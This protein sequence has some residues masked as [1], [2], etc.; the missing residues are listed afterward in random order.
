MSEFRGGGQTDEGRARMDA[1]RAAAAVEDQLRRE[2]GAVPFVRDSDTSIAAARSMAAHAPRLAR[3]VYRLVEQAGGRGITCDEAEA[4][5]QLPHQTISA[6]FRDLALAEQ[7]TDS[8]D[9]RET[10]QGRKARV[11]IVRSQP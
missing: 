8:G 3:E 5:L 2:P 9:R 6:R 7:I 1:A 4:V 11:Y 10:R